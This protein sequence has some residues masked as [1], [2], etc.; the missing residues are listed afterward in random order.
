MQNIEAVRTPWAVLC[1]A[2]CSVGSPESATF[3]EL[4]G[5]E[6]NGDRFKQGLRCLSEAADRR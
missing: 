4:V 3:P 5:R 2:F 6:G 1:G